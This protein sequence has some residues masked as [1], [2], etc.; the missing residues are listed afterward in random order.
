[1]FCSCLIAISCAVIEAPRSIA[2]ARISLI[3][4]SASHDAVSEGHVSYFTG[5]D[6]YIRSY[7]SSILREAF[8]A[9]NK[10][11]KLE[12]QGIGGKST[13]SHID[14]K[15]FVYI[16]YVCTTSIFNENFQNL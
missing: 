1:M 12:N 13:C 10:C 4:L 15:V 2:P 5:E 3:S 9:N 14:G 8:R 11:D 6:I 16:D 7:Y